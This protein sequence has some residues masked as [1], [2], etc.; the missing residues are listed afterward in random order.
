M[1]VDATLE[2]RSV[3]LAGGSGGIGS[4][5]AGHVASRGGIPVI[6][7]RRD[8]DRAE[9]LSKEI[10]G[11]YG[12]RPVLVAGD[13]LDGEVRRR[14]LEA[15]C[16]AGV[17]YALVPLVGR[18]ARVPIEEAS[19]DDLLESTRVNFVAPVLLARDFAAL[20][21]GSDSTVVFV[22]TMQALGVFSGS[23]VYAA[24]KAALLHT[25]RILAKQWGGSGRIRVNV[26]APG[27]TRAGMA[28]ASVESGKYDPYLERDVVIRFGEA[29]DVARAVGYFLEPDNYVTG[30]VL[31]VDG[32]MTTRM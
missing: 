31:A 14:L 20:V 30:Q 11:R 10:E 12:V 28:M 16:S 29:A 1:S 15:A 8:V 24:P 18:P 22:S 3:V 9:S 2:G 23:T 32:G 4:A 25:A 6:G 17:P 5:V 7:F 27:V 13:I 26:V 19:E 21:R